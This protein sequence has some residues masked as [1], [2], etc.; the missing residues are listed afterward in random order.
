[1][2][3]RGTVFA[4]GTPFPGSGSTAN[5]GLS[6]RANSNGRCTKS[7][8]IRGVSQRNAAYGASANSPIKKFRNPGSSCNGADIGELYGIAVQTD[9]SDP[10]GRCL[11]RVDHILCANQGISC[12]RRSL[13][14]H[15]LGATSIVRID[16]WGEGDRTLCTC[17]WPW[18][19]PASAI[20]LPQ[21]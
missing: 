9:A 13:V 21:I 3:V 19:C 20:Q 1:V 16:S 14:D 17:Q 6:R 18:K 4:L 15:Q 12:T 10:L 5:S 8:E 11:V 7:A 2:S